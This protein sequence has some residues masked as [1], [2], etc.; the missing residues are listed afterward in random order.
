MAAGLER[1]VVTAQDVAEAAGVSRW[2]VT[3][4]FRPGGSISEATRK[5]VMDA[6]ARLGYVPDRQAAGL[7]A[8]HSGLVA[9]LVDDFANPFKLV[10][11]EAITAA[12]KASGRD[13]LFVNMAGQD[14]SGALLSASQRRVDAA[15]LI[16]VEFDPATL[17][18]ELG[19]R[20][21]NQ[22]IVFG[23]YA[24]H[25]LAR[26]VTPDDGRA[27]SE[28]AAY[29]HG[30]GYGRALFLA[31]PAPGAGHVER[32]DRF[33]AI[34]PDVAGSA[35]EVLE[36]GSYDPGLG[37]EAVAEALAGRSEMPQVIVCENDALAMGA[38]DAVR[39]KLGLRV[40]EDIAV[41]GFDDVP[42]ASSPN[43]RLTTYRQ[44]VEAMAEALVALLDGETDDEA[45]VLPGELV[46]RDSA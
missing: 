32:K 18:N 46:L 17:D 41:T 20:R 24:D 10:M 5:K 4:A 15:I 42:L 2:T 3:R 40:P 25:P 37:L 28:L 45:C 31:G 1:E 36:A 12:L 27:M 29:L 19:A 44:P 11:L 23:Q 8:G 22:L 43:Y 38:V 34:W 26:S 35:V 21:V 39:H 13:T 30:R 33:C 7:R 6:V 9:L 16:G 14:T